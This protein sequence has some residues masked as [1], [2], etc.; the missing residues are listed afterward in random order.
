MRL[1]CLPVICI[2]LFIL[3][4][5]CQNYNLSIP[6]YIKD[7]TSITRGISWTFTTA[8]KKG[9]AEYYAIPPDTGSTQPSIISVKL[10][11]PQKYNL[12]L[13]VEDTG[14]TLGADIVVE[15]PAGDEVLIYI[16]NAAIGDIYRLTLNMETDE[17]RK[18]EKYSISPIICNSD[19]SA[20]TLNVITT[21]TV[22]EANWSMQ[23]QAQHPGIKKATL[24]FQRRK[25]GVSQR[26]YAPDVLTWN[27]T[28]FT[29]IPSGRTAINGGKIR[30]PMNYDSALV[31]GF[32]ITIEDEYGFS[33]TG[34][35]AEF[36]DPREVQD[37]YAIEDI[38]ELIS[39]I[40]AGN[41]GTITFFGNA[42][43]TSIDQPIN[44]TGGRTITIV[45]PDGEDAAMNRVTGYLGNFFTVDSFSSL[46]LGSE[47][48][49][50]T[51][52][53]DGKDPGGFPNFDSLVA[54]NGGTVI[55]HENTTLKNN[56]S[57][58]ISAIG[59]GP[60]AG[61]HIRNGGDFIM[62]GGVING[63]TSNWDGRGG[64]VFVE[65]GT[66]E[67]YSGAMIRDNSSGGTNAPGGGGG[68]YVGANGIFTMYGGEIKNNTA[69]C[70]G[71][72][73]YISTGG[74]FIMNGGNIFSNSTLN[75]NY[76]GGFKEAGTT[77]IDGGGINGI[78]DNTNF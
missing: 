57:G 15:Q 75:G 55:M 67:M 30:F 74:R 69:E 37:M 40:P 7:K 73:I 18:F 72:G 68:V 52:T 29:D 78:T 12:V 6:A 62:K 70:E 63:N 56:H 8:A 32:E 43:G 64:G 66:F 25:D 27:G 28:G 41:S 47:T 53:L 65:N 51:L 60:C 31:Y 13:N 46:T 5:N 23:T 61:V 77:V 59:T 17:G 26:T 4:S 42:S 22:P 49:T 35:S 14:T 9:G 58:D 33:Y 16:N 50:G 36:K 48:G 21:G 38:I 24:R 20:G 2:I 71:G 54:V 11:N 45:V 10:L 76:D 1:F 39:N 34:S 44:I 19:L 3:L